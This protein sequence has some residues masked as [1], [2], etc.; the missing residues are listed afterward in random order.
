MDDKLYFFINQQQKQD[1]Y[2]NTREEIHKRLNHKNNDW[3]F[4]DECHDFVN[5]IKENHKENHKIPN[6]F[7]CRECIEIMKVHFKIKN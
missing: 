5:I 1:D 7:W 3:T 4:C 2:V 6:W